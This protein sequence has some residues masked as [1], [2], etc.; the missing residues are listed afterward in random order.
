MSRRVRITQ[1]GLTRHAELAGP[2]DQ[3]IG[4]YADRQVAQMI[5]R[6]GLQS[7]DD[8]NDAAV[9][10]LRVASDQATSARLR[11]AI[12]VQALVIARRLIWSGRSDAPVPTATGLAAA[13]I[14]VI[15]LPGSSL[16]WRSYAMALHKSDRHDEALVAGDQALALE[17]ASTVSG[18]SQVAAPNGTGLQGMQDLDLSDAGRIGPGQVHRQVPAVV[19]YMVLFLPYLLYLVLTVTAGVLGAAMI[20]AAGVPGCYLLGLIDVRA[21]RPADRSGN[22]RRP[23]LPDQAEPAQV[24]YFYGRR[25]PAFADIGLALKAGGHR[26]RHLVARAGRLPRVELASSRPISRVDQ[27][28][29]TVPSGIGAF[30]GAAVGLIA[31]APAFAFLALLDAVAVSAAVIGVTSAGLVLRAIDTGLLRIRNTRVTCPYCLE[32]VSHPAYRCSSCGLLHYDLR[33]GRHGLFIR[34]C[35]C[36]HRMPTLLIASSQRTAVCPSAGCGRLL[37]FP[38]RAREQEVVLPFFG[39]AGAGKT[40]LIYGIM[41]VLRSARYPRAELADASL[42]LQDVHALLTSRAPARTAADLPQGQTLRMTN[43]RTRLIRLCEPPGESFSAPEKTSEFDWLGKARTFVI[44]I[45]PFAIDQLWQGLP[46]DR[47]AELAALRSHGPSPG[48]V[49]DQGLQQLEAMGIRLSKARL[50]V[51]FSRADLL[52]ELDQPTEDWVTNTL[53]LGN[54]VRSAKAKFGQVAFFRT[55][56]VLDGTF[57][58]HSSLVELTRWLL[59][60]E[61]IL[62]PGGQKTAA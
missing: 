51:V 25:S 26:A 5:L 1:P 39:A 6:A 48:Q 43:G 10:A 9:A 19:A 61:G 35:L 27:R 15:T 36:G 57:L 3:S 17:T 21:R 52:S 18:T 47:Q 44:V 56:S 24:S 55:A 45:D 28:L 50:A 29:I 13:E 14:A 31:G 32:R 16:A 4:A 11:E 20:C 30:V 42:D 34:R 54:L 23:Q 59:T 8:D 40:R 53:A 7:A 49:Y 2:D 60:S 58:A 41:T 38:S 46:A 33:P 37:E 12:G 62:L 22:S